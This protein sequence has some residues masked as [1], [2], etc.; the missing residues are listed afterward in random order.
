MEEIKRRLV[1][2]IPTGEMPGEANESVAGLFGGTGVPSS[3]LT[4][5]P[6]FTLN[7]PIVA[8]QQAA[9]TDHPVS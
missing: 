6:L 8:W 9:V 4:S 5:L 1:W 2:Q 3:S 7:I